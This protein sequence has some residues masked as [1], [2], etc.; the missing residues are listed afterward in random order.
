MTR[1]ITPLSFLVLAACGGAS[2]SPTAGGSEG[3]CMTRAYSQIGGP[4]ALTDHTGA[5]V[6]E[7]DFA[8]APAM[9]FFGFT[10]CPDVCPMTL[11]TL[12]QA[13]SRLPDG[14]APPKT[15]LISVDPERDTP[16]ALAS[17]ISTGAFP[18]DIT[19][20]TGST[21]AIRAAA[22][23]FVADYQRIETPESLA[24]YTMDHTSLLYL[25]N[26]NWELA[27]FFTHGDDPDS[28]ASCLAEHLG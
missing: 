28:M 2:P 3:G 8:G 22:D 26:D 25:M 9:V 21:E 10:Y 16:E 27:T 7:A 5:A 14:V 23:A 4:I 15:V 18:D 20:L 13:Y 11:V 19:G 12:E 1:W 24:T 17:Y 6:T